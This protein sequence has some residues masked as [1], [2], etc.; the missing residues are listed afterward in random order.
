MKR[1]VS[2]GRIAK[3]SPPV[4]LSLIGFTIEDK[5]WIRQFPGA[6]TK[7]HH[8]R[9]EKMAL[10]VLHGHSGLAHVLGYE[11]PTTSAPRLQPYCPGDQRKA[12]HV[13]NLL[14]SSRGV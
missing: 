5:I 3:R 10:Q 1:K 6:G 2:V 13:E 4:R 12:V 8:L 9:R 14:P 11:D 7:I